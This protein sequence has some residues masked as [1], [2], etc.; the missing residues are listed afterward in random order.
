LNGRVPGYVDTSLNVVDVDD[1]ALGQLA[2]LELGRQGRSYI[3]GG[4]NLSF[5]EILAILADETGLP[6]P[7]VRV[8]AGVALGAA[9]VSELVEGRIVRRP[10]SVPLEGAKMATTQMIYSDERARR[11]LGYRSR[12]ARDALTRSARWFVDNGYVTDKR[13]A[14]IRWKRPEPEPVPVGRPE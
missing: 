5:R 1:L 3:L 10:P 7:R 8:P 6:R 13:R 14:R 4:E 12:P 9:Y 11:E 2:A